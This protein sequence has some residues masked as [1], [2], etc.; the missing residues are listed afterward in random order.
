MAS[1]KSL[2]SKFAKF[3]IALLSVV[4]VVLAIFRIDCFPFKITN[5]RFDAFKEF[6]IFNILVQKNKKKSCEVSHK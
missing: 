4:M 3:A 5:F 6:T 1:A 2:V